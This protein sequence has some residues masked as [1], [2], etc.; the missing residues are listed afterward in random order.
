MGG[1]SE[2][3]DNAFT[4]HIPQIIKLETTEINQWG[5]DGFL[6]VR[7]KQDNSVSVCSRK[8]A[9]GWRH[10]YDCTKLVAITSS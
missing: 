2:H 6:C 1:G 5:C 8:R 3:M 4:K 10:L 9:V 7:E